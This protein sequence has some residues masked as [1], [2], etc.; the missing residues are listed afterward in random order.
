MSSP[1]A[2]EP[3]AS[4][5]GLD[6]GYSDLGA[7]SN[8]ADANSSVTEEFLEKKKDKDPEMVDLAEKA[9]DMAKRGQSPPRKSKNNALTV[10]SAQPTIP[11]VKDILISGAINF[12]LP[13]INGMM[14]GFGEIFAHELGFRWGWSAARVSLVFACDCIQALL[15]LFYRY[16]QPVEW[17]FQVSR[18]CQSKREALKEDFCYS[19]DDGTSTIIIQTAIKLWHYKQINTSLSTNTFAVSTSTCQ[20]FCHRAL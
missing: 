14:L 13:F 12:V 20:S 19:H 17:Q 18:L 6:S 7:P 16:Y 5:F 4:P 15:T 1:N 9:E 11:S 10:A 2:T 8:H 3:A